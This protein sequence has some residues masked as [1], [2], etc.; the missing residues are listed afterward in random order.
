MTSFPEGIEYILYSPSTGIQDVFGVSVAVALVAIFAVASES[1]VQYQVKVVGNVQSGAY[2]CG[3][4]CT[5]TG[6][7]SLRMNP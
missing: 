1:L 7:C 3:C 6:V 5:A 4:D 2:N